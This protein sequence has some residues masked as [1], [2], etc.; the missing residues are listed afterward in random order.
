MAEEI[1]NQ[2]DSRVGRKVTWEIYGLMFMGTVKS[3]FKDKDGDERLSV[4]VETEQ[5]EV[6]P[7]KANRHPG[8]PASIYPPG[9]NGKGNAMWV[10]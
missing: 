9:T 4:E 6:S 8:I 1:E 5:D 2:V 10:N 3:V 7:A